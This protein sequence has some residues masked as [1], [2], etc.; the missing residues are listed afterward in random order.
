MARVVLQKDEKTLLND[1][2]FP[3]PKNIQMICE[4]IDDGK[5]P[6]QIWRLLNDNF[7]TN[8]EIQIAFIK[9]VNV[10]SF[11]SISQFL[12]ED[13]GL[14]PE[15]FYALL[16]TLEHISFHPLTLPTKIHLTIILS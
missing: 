15:T 12:Q 8:L 9:Q 1:L 16:S 14:S 7:K 13:G 10:H 2:S 5:S 11:S 6:I 3:T 4:M